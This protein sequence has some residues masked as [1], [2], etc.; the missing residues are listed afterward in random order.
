MFNTFLFNTNLYNTVAFTGNVDVSNF[1]VKVW[2]IFF[3]SEKICLSGMPDIDD[4]PAINFKTYNIA[5]TDWMGASEHTLQSKTITLRGYIIG[6]HRAEMEEIMLDLKKSLFKKGQRFI[7]NRG[8]GKMVY[9]TVHLSSVKFDR[10][11]TTINVM[12]FTIQFI[13]LEPFFYN[14][15]LTEYSAL[16]QTAEIRGAVQYN[17][18]NYRAYPVLYLWFTSATDVT[19][20]SFNI[21]WVWLTI[22]ESIS[23]WDFLLI[24]CKKKEVSINGVPGVDYTG[25]F[26]ELAL[27][28]SRFAVNTNGTHD[29]DVYMQWND[30]YV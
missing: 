26:P 10:T 30:T 16:S 22:N 25:S 17:E 4:W 13:T 28:E 9:T 8:D 1:L 15:V 21:E 5:K 14:T 24:D 11:S 18:G 12:P 3:P 27:W 6:E 20:V 2:D 7:Y 19:E 23:D 29:I